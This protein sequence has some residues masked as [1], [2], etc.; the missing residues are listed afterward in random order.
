M[1]FWDEKWIIL[2]V[3]V[4]LY[5]RLRGQLP[6]HESWKAMDVMLCQCKCRVDEDA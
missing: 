2:T 3:E 6:P 4:A 1:Q 5:A